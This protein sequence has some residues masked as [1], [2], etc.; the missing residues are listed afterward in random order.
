MST[1]INDVGA[2]HHETVEIV[3]KGPIKYDPALARDTARRMIE[4]MVELC[5][6]CGLHPGE[7]HLHVTDALHNE[8]KKKGVYPSS[9]EIGFAGGIP[10]E[11]V[12][13]RICLD[14]LRHVVGISSLSIAKMEQD[15]LKSL[16]A[17]AERS[18][19]I[20]VGR[21]IYKKDSRQ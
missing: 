12:D 11:I 13:N 9:L 4:E 7:I 15:K 20:M 3:N 1:I 2:Y 10:G 8:A 18:D 5:L 19:Y 16:R 14:Y 6:D 21:R 17:R